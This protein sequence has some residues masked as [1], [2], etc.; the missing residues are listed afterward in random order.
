VGI[1]SYPIKGV[2]FPDVA[3]SGTPRPVAVAEPDTKVVF[4]PT[5]DGSTPAPFTGNV[6]GASMEWKAVFTFTQ[7]A[8]ATVWTINHSLDHKPQCTVY[9]NNEVVLADVDAET[10]F[11]VTVTFQDPH[12]GYVEVS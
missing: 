4:V 11:V 12:V 6:L 8:P 5:T 9:V 1:T 10:P 3:I 7:N 2:V